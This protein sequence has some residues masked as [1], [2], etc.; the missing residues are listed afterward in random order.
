MRQWINT[1]IATARASATAT[2]GA[3]TATTARQKQKNK[4]R[5]EWCVC[6]G[7]RQ[8]GCVADSAVSRA[9]DSAGKQKHLLCPLFGRFG[10][11]SRTEGG[12]LNSPA[13]TQPFRT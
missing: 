4:R 8:H 13:L 12:Q 3:T 1:S 2:T 7:L 6:R 9:N 11:G 5:C 10:A